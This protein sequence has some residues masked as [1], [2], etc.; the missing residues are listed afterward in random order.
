MDQVRE[1]EKDESSTF[2]SDAVD[3]KGAPANRS[4]TGGW[5]SAASILGI[6]T[7]PF[8]SFLDLVAGNKINHG[9]NARSFSDYVEF[10]FIYSF[11]VFF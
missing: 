8:I 10:Y 7:M 2:I 3:Y 1:R 9:K 11:W 6:R 4:T 5:L